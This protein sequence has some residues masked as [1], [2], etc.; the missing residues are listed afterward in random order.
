MVPYFGLCVFHLVLAG[1]EGPEV[2]F[3]LIRYLAEARSVPTSVTI[4]G[5]RKNRAHLAL[6]ML[7]SLC[8]VMC[9]PLSLHD[10]LMSSHYLREGVVVQEL[11]EW[12]LTEHFAHS[13]LV[14][15]EAL[16]LIISRVVPK[17][18]THLAQT[19]YFGDSI[20]GSYLFIS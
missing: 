3:Q 17:Y 15:S 13:S 5:C 20:E 8:D 10:D 11:L 16:E 7:P 14:L 4:I 6:P 9:V 12:L 18:L 2:D 19:G 1:L